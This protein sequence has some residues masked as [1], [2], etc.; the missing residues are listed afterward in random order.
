MNRE[1]K[2]TMQRRGQLHE[3]EPEAD[4]PAAVATARPVTDAAADGGARAGRAGRTERGRT[5]PRNTPIQFLREVRDELRQVAWPSREE[6]VS[7]STV[8]LFTLVLM[9]LA[10]FAMNFVF[11]KAVFFMFQ[12]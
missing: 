8:V 9:V 7:Y 1:T 5:T 2:R 6:I 4:G 10:I 12:K 11:G 3:G